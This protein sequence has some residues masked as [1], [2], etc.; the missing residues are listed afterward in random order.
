MK[1]LA[2]SRTPITGMGSKATRQTPGPCGGC[3]RGVS[4]LHQELHPLPPS[5]LPG[6]IN[7]REG[8][9]PMSPQFGS[10]FLG[11]GA[12]GL[13]CQRPLPSPLRSSLPWGSRWARLPIFCPM[14]SPRQ[15]VDIVGRCRLWGP[16]LHAPREK[17][18]RGG[19]AWLGWFLSAPEF[20]GQAVKQR[21][22]RLS[23]YTLCP[24]HPL[25]PFLLSLSS[26][27]ME[28]PKFERGGLCHRHA[29][30]RASC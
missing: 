28:N 6:Q 10:S 23:V 18:G 26:L 8:H 25:P 22:P 14:E 17:A 7:A 19:A 9:F 15:R 29:I 3:S 12:E 11:W 16:R 24:A 2:R 21:S 20:F 30:S 4:V 5:S 27:T 13:L 1:P